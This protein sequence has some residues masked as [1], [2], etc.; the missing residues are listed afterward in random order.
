[1]QFIIL[2]LTLPV[3]VQ[4]GEEAER[5]S[6]MME[7]KLSSAKVLQVSFQATVEGLPEGGNFK[8][9]MTLAEGNKV[10]L[11]GIIEIKG[12]RA[13]WLIVSDGARMK[14]QGI[15]SDSRT[16]PEKLTENFRGTFRHGGFVAGLFLSSSD[17]EGRESWATFRASEFKLGKKEPVGKRQAQ[18]IVYKLTPLVKLGEKDGAFSETVWLDLDTNLPLKRIFNGRV[19]GKEFTFTETYDTFTLEP[20]I[21]AKLFEVPK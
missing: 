4:H 21:D 7:K 10:H 18:V 19:E 8:G 17:S 5:R 1:M 12:K 6:Q 13:D 15:E 3:V 11:K 9:T 16:T 14:Q 20:K 2:A